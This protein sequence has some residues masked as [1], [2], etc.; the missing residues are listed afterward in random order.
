MAVWYLICDYRPS[1][2][3]ATMYSMTQTAAAGLATDLKRSPVL[4]AVCIGLMLGQGCARSEPLRQSDASPK[5]SEQKLPFHAVTEHALASDEAHPAV[6]PDQTL[7]SLP[8]FHGGSQPRTLPFGILLTVQLSRSLSAPRNHAGDAFTALITAPLTIEGETLVE[9]GTP[10]TGVIESSQ[11]ADR[12]GR[13]SSPGYFQLT[14]STL[15]LHGRPVT[16]QT[17]SLFAR[18]TPQPA[19]VASRSAVGGV[20]KGRRLTFRLTAPVDLPV[21]R[22]AL[23]PS[24]GGH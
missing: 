13:M 1:G 9:R 7:T 8:P 20:Q 10:V 16:L 4:I 17:S 14:L 2:N 12:Q 15:I 18:A 3:S 21:D 11:P 22:E 6:P 24:A 23:Q 19:N 5:L